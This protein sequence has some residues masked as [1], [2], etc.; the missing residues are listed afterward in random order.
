[1][2]CQRKVLEFCT[3]LAETTCPLDG[4]P[5]F[6]AREV[7]ALWYYYFRPMEMTR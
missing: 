5:Y 7:L 4:L 6:A 2:A 1:M 3:V